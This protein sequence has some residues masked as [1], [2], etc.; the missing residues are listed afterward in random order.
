MCG[1]GEDEDDGGGGVTGGGGLPDGW[2]AFISPE[3]WEYFFH[4]KTSVVQ[5][6][7]PTG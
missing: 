4:E 2:T 7:R 6:E 3:G 5:W 1:E